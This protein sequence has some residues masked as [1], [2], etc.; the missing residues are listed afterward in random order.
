LAK[1]EP[2]FYPPSIILKKNAKKGLSWTGFSVLLALVDPREEF[3][4]G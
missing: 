1:V 4:G 2:G 3:I